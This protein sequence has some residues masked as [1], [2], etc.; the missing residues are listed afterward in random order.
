M[1]REDTDHPKSRC[2]SLP[3]VLFERLAKERGKSQNRL[4]THPSVSRIINF[5]RSLI[6]YKSRLGSNCVLMYKPGPFLIPSPASSA[7]SG[8]IPLSDEVGTPSSQ[9]RLLFLTPS[10]PGCSN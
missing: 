1:R 5:R 3:Q 4:L 6:H 10:Q 2:R 7:K 8:V 9:I